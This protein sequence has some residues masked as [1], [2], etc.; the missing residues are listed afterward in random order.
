MEKGNFSMIKLRLKDGSI[1]EAENGIPAFEAIK[2]IGMGLYKS[3]CCVKI[4][5]EVK[6]LRTVLNNDCDFEV[7][8]FDSKD[9]KKAFWHTASHILA[10]A[11]KRLYPSVKL[12]IGPAIDNGAIGS[13]FTVF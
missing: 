4:D 2:G 8:T 13:L 7:M 9:G 3:A 6:D 5:G 11:V 12:A 10:Q 1:R